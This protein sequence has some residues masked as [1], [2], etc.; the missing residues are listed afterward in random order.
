MD[1]QTKQYERKVGFNINWDE[2]RKDRLADYYTRVSGH[3]AK[4]IGVA[5]NGTPLIVFEEEVY[6]ND[7]DNQRESLLKR[8]LKKFRIN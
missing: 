1:N 2:Y 7:C 4:C 5:K 8:I 6:N 3:K